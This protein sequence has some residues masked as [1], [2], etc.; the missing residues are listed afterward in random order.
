MVCGIFHCNVLSQTITRMLLSES[1]EKCMHEDIL[2]TVKA[3][4]EDHIKV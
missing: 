3:F 2:H 4:T 1:Y